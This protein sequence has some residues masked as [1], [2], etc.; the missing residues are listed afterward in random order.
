MIICSASL[1]VRLRGL[2]TQR[3]RLSPKLRKIDALNVMKMLDTS[4]KINCLHLK[5]GKEE[6]METLKKYALVVIIWIFIAALTITTTVRAEQTSQIVSPPLKEYRIV[7][8]VSK[9][10][11]E[12]IDCH[13]QKSRGIVADWATSRHAHANISCL[14]CHIAGPAD[15]DISKDH[16]Q[17]DKT[18]ISV[19]V[20]PK[21]CSR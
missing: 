20:S 6:T 17:H 8:S 14:D 10:A 15:A 18:P 21:D 11:Q 1:A 2:R 16:L 12:C 4:V 19:I 3:F 7:R 13:A 9:D 5:Q